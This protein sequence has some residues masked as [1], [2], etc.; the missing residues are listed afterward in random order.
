MCTATISI[1]IWD[2]DLVRYNTFMMTQASTNR[3]LYAS[4]LIRNIEVTIVRQVICLRGPPRP[5]MAPPDAV[6]PH[7]SPLYRPPAARLHNS[8]VLF[9]PSILPS[10]FSLRSPQRVPQC[11][12]LAPFSCIPILMEVTK[13]PFIVAL[14]F[15]GFL[16]L[17]SWSAT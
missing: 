12:F 6:A 13:S 10:H 1:N 2:I 17:N 5:E 7:P 14:G 11:I 16:G 3:T 4:T 8:T 15:F 9:S